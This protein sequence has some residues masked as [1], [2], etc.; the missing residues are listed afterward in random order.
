[1]KRCIELVL[2]ILCLV[3]GAA[4]ALAEESA[5]APEMTA[6]RGIVIWDG[7]N[8]QLLLQARFRHAAG[9]IALV[10]PL[11]PDAST[12]VLAADPAVF[13]QLE[14]RLAGTGADAA[15]HPWP[16]QKSNLN[17]IAR[18][19]QKGADA[20]KTLSDNALASLAGA[21]ETEKTYAII[22]YEVPEDVAGGTDELVTELVGLS[23]SQLR[24]PA[25][26]CKETLYFF[27]AQSG[28]ELPRYTE[29][30]KELAFSCIHQGATPYFWGRR[31]EPELAAV[32]ALFARDAGQFYLNAVIPPES[33][34]LELRNAPLP[35]DKPALTDAL[36]ALASIKKISDFIAT[37][38]EQQLDARQLEDFADALEERADALRRIIHAGNPPSKTVNEFWSGLANATAD[39]EDEAKAVVE[40]LKGLFTAQCWADKMEP[41]LARLGAVEFVKEGK[42]NAQLYTTAIVSEAVEHDTARVIFQMLLK[43]AE[44][45]KAATVIQQTYS[46]KYETGKWL[47]AGIEAMP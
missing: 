9:K 44:G 26:P 25:A 10:L 43:P 7:R 18:L 22:I 15:A 21:L 23:F 38:K 37:A 34:T 33:K 13:D 30:G 24:L 4:P 35:P 32:K 31:L 46:L 8:E 6:L 27:S 3:S 36:A 14:L 1:M 47:I 5:Q 28:I 16:A 42:K 45:E 19:V 11:P 17:N 41:I 2:I 40:N 29:D 12:T 20:K 39:N